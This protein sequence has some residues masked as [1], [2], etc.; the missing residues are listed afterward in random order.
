MTFRTKYGHVIEEV[1]GYWQLYEKHRQ[2]PSV[3]AT[4]EEHT[5]FSVNFY[6]FAKDLF[7]Y[8]FMMDLLGDNG[9]E[10]KVARALDV[11]G[12]EGTV[13]RLLKNSGQAAICDCVD[14]HDYGRTLTDE[15]F[16]SYLRSYRRLYRWRPGKVLMNFQEHFDHRLNRKRFSGQ[17]AL[18]K[19]FDIDNYFT[20][21]FQA[22]DED[23]QYDFVS[24]LGCLTYFELNEF[25]HKLSKVLV[26]GGLFYFFADCWWNQCNSTG[27]TGGFPWCI[28]RLESDD[29]LRYFREWHPEVSLLE[30]EGKLNY[31][32]KGKDRPTITD[33]VNAACDHGFSVVATRRH[34][35]RAIDNERIYALARDLY[36]RTPP[37]E[38][39]RDIGHFKKG[40]SELDLRT[41]FN[42][43]VFVRN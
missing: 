15:K 33:I 23:V 17:L 29:A 8:G 35:A 27:I 2:S 5:R 30:I 14:I 11:G 21:G 3:L 6:A 42:S 26:R 10:L 12:M 9:V 4:D 28:Q 34:I 39:L 36:A 7:E 41:S 18:G 24:G 19:R 20:C 43:A 38:V 1:D 13:S 25:F 40:V 31:Y 22:M 16:V 37:A 32:H